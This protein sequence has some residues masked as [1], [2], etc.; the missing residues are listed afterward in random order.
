MKVQKRGKLW[1]VL[2]G[3]TVVGKYHTRKYA[4]GVAE[5]KRRGDSVL[6]FDF[7]ASL[8]EIHFDKNRKDGTFATLTEDGFLRGVANG[9]RANA[10]FV[11]QDSAGAKWGELRTQEEVFHPD[12]LASYELAPVTD[13][14]P[15]EFVSVD[16]ARELSVGSIGAAKKDGDFVQFPYLITDRDV[17]RGVVDGTKTELSMGYSAIMVAEKGDLRGAKYD[18]KQT[19]IRVNHCAVVDRGRAGPECRI[20]PLQ[21]GDA[22]TTTITKELD[23]MKTKKITVDGVDYVVPAELADALEESANLELI[24]LAVDAVDAKDPP[25]LVKVKIKGKSVMVSEEAAA[26][27]KGDEAVVTVTTGEETEE[28]KKKKAAAKKKTGDDSELEGRIAAMEAKSKSDG[29]SFQKRV[30]ERVHLVSQVRTVFGVKKK[31]DGVSDL[32]LK[33]AV[34]DE[35]FPDMKD[36]LDSMQ[37]HDDS[38]EQFLSGVFSVACDQHKQTQ[39]LMDDENL[40]L[41]SVHEDNEDADDPDVAYNSYLDGLNKKSK[42]SKPKEA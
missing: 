29:E 27:L 32:E 9:T 7:N 37:E 20:P 5:K 4:L 31:T 14:H 8:G 22:F 21:R 6:R 36:K 16:N 34:V 35:V 28:E 26:A 38:Y 18:Y 10:V 2:D 30:D 19:N 12:S 3:K 40:S 1:L 33:R 11:Y 41:F 24:K 15:A 42:G 39:R 25:K 23:K 13:D 17:I